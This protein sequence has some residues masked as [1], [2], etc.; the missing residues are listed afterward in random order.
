MTS[1]PPRPASSVAPSAAKHK[2]LIVRG[3]E[4]VREREASRGGGA[5]RQALQ[6][7]RANSQTATA[8]LLQ[9]CLNPTS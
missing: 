6:E 7:L 2:S 4:K 1:P 8:S 3:R 9:L 5:A